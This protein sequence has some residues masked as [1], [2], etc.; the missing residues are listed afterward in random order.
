MESMNESTNPQWS[1]HLEG[2]AEELLHLS[3]ACDVRLRDA[4]VVDRILRD[5]A[6]VCGRKN[7]IGFRKLRRLLMA[8]F[9]SLDKAIHRIG[10]EETQKILD[11]ISDHIDRLRNL[12]GTQT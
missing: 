5:D 12:G 11:E 8:T 1:R 3:I 7:E 4:G 2:I 10:P 9:D 6:S